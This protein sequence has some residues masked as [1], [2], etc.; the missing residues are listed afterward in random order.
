MLCEVASSFPHLVSLDLSRTKT[1]DQALTI[2]AHHCY[3]LLELKLT[4][5]PVT[6][7]SMVNLCVTLGPQDKRKCPLLKKLEI[8]DTMVG[9]KG[10]KTVLE[11]VPTLQWLEHPMTCLAVAEIHKGE[12]IENIP[13]GNLHTLTNLNL[14]LN[15]FLLGNNH[16]IQ[17]YVA[18]ACALCPRTS[19]VKMEVPVGFILDALTTLTELHTLHLLSDEY[20]D[21]EDCVPLLQVRGSQLTCLY[22]NEFFAVDLDLLGSL[23]P[24]LKRL[25]IVYH[26]DPGTFTVGSHPELVQA[27]PP[28][29]QIFSQLEELKL[30]C[31][32][33]CDLVP[34]QLTS[35]LVR[36]V[37]LKFLTL[38]SIHALTDDVLEDVLK[39]NPL[40]HL[41]LLHLD[42]CDSISG[43]ALHA[44]MV[45]DNELKEL[46]LMECREVSRAHY[47]DLQDIARQKNYLINIYWD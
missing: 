30:F 4:G 22:L 40:R 35:L 25:S 14:H 23:C 11:N 20:E 21:F 15:E 43:E 36:C 42:N 45:M 47:N 28:N 19:T 38:N 46:L 26:N 44:L 41:T 32:P 27:G 13:P 12:D 31:F 33:G 7:N 29:D 3:A 24:N 6:D 5:C 18:T 9:L 8:N 37:A 34:A 10:I 16:L 1:S 17:P 39:V 2:L